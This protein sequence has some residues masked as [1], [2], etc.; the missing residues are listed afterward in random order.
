ML[1][2]SSL[3]TLVDFPS[4]G[5]F[6]QGRGGPYAEFFEKL[7]R[8]CYMWMIHS[9]AMYSPPDSP[10][11]SLLDLFGSMTDSSSVASVVDSVA[12]T[13]MD[14][15]SVETD[16]TDCQPVS[17]KNR[18]CFSMEED[19]TERTAV[20]GV[21]SLGF[22][23]ACTGR[24]VSY[25]SA[26]CEEYG[27]GT[28]VQRHAQ[29]PL[30][31]WA[32]YAKGVSTRLMKE[33]KGLDPL[34]HYI[35]TGSD[36][37]NWMPD[38]GASSHFAPCLLDLQEVE[39]GLNLGV[40][41]A[42]GHTVKCTARVIVEVQP[43]K[44]HLH[45][46][47]YVLG[48]KRCLF[49]VTS[50]ASRGQYAIVRKNEIQLM[51]GQEERPLTLML[52]NGMHV[53]NNATVKKFTTV[54]EDVK[55]QSQKKRIDLELAHARFVRP[56]RAL[57]AASSA[58]VWNDLTIRMSPD[59]DCI[60]CRISTIKATAMIKHQSTPINKPGQVTYVD[61]LP[62]VSAESLTPKSNFPALLILVETFSRL[63]RYQ[64]HWDAQ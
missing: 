32:Y 27:E 37:R 19:S 33:A 48:L 52:K 2:K 39:E 49:S 38:T 7:N 23:L 11:T 5:P 25:A 60:S 47:I 10:E 13:H 28:P 53:T 20:S 1:G 16:Y 34:Y 18:F 42:D 41:V 29:L 62:P 54:P 24:A 31:A 44:A 63:P 61:I 57:L 21:H 14:N 43:L 6:E 30:V 9:A 46:V 64:D 58:E 35:G 22:S 56:S 26:S 36:L 17:P 8:I 55:Q 3:G 40:E 59:S 50:F 4:F 15:D 51:F 12:K 45:G